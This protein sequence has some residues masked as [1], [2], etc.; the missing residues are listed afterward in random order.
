MVTGVPSMN[1]A[2]EDTPAVFLRRDL[3]LLSRDLNV[4]CSIRAPWFIAMQSVCPCGLRISQKQQ[5][6][7]V[8]GCHK[9]EQ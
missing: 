2:L 4:T 5:L 3:S 7:N 1:L 6:H 8:C 9:E